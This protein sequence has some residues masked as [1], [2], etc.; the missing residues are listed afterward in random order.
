MSENEIVI[1]GEE[2]CVIEEF[3]PGAYT[4]SDERGNVRATVT[5]LVK[6]DLKTHDIHVQP[7][8]GRSLPSQGDIIIGKVVAMLNEKVAVVKICAVQREN[9]KLEVLKHSYT[10]LLHVVQASDQPTPNMSIRDVV[11]IGDIV[12]ARVISIKG[13]PFLLSLKGQNLGVIYALCPF[14]R[15]E[16]RKRGRSLQCPSCGQIFKRKIP[17]VE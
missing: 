12:R 14:C 5:G 7:L 1:P 9:G 15:V 13:P 8:R 6:R 10:G 2:L 11:G 16:L 17:V 3:L 4:Y